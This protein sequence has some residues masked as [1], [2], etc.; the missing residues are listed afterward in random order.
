MNSQAA[1]TA[2]GPMIIVAADQYE[3]TPLVRD[4]LAGKLLPPTGR[5]AATALRF[6]L[7]RRVL[8][9]ATDKQFRGGWDS[10]LCRKRYIDDQLVAALAD[11]IGQVVVLGAGYD[12]RAY[13]LPEL[14]GIPVFEVDLPANIARKAAAVRRALG[15]VPAGVKLV[16]V[17][18]E[19]D[20]LTQA[21][22]AAGFDRTIRTFYVWEAV[23]QY[24]T[25]PAVRATMD[26]IADAAAGSRLA[27]TY[28]RKDFLDGRQRYGAEKAYQ[29]FV[30][31]RG[32]WKFG[33][34]PDDVA[35]FL[36]GYGWREIEQLGPDEYRARYPDAA[37]RSLTPSPIERTVLAEA[38]L[39]DKSPA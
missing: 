7:V 37:G 8:E 19:T 20:D 35:G 10:F 17:D 14:A 36:A 6:P 21:L 39:Q 9:S 24:L 31:K 38:G 5:A 23:T 11:G 3:D 26:R 13:R 4:P 12:T 2:I 28:V 25:E 30:V 33:L 18:F 32:L 29:D 34:N 27:F 1:Q 22:G 15:A 16:P